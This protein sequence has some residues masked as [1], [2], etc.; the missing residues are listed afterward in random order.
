MSSLLIQ[1]VT[2]ADC[3]SPNYGIISISVTMCNPINIFLSSVPQFCV[4]FW[5]ENH[6]QFHAQIHYLMH[7]LKA[8]ALFGNRL[9]R[10]IIIV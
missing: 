3:E 10:H 4:S 1:S 9:M 7:V 6:N 2:T 5:L 8:V